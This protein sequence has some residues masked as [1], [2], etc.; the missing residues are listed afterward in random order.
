[1]PS[2]R[3]P[4]L[5]LAALILA[6]V[7][8]SACGRKTAVRPPEAVAPATIESLTVVNAIEGVRL[9]WRRPKSTADGG[10]L[11][12]L[13]GFTIERSISGG[14]YTLLTSI[15]VAD[16]DR[17][18]QARRFRYVDTDTQVGELY[19]YLVFAATLDGYISAPSNMAQV[20]RSVP[21]VTPTVAPTQAPTATPPLR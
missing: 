2:L 17:L 18:R 3:P 7:T 12:D 14:P 13:A 15:D 21:T 19:S 9:S 20:V 4:A 6:A 16:R 5:L 11:F 8:W 10:N 1:M